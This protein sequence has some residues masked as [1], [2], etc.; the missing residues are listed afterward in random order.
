[1]NKTTLRTACAALALLT[2]GALTAQAQTQP[3]MERINA[4]MQKME[5]TINQLM[6][7]IAELEKERDAARA[8]A[9]PAA[10]AATGQ[11]GAPSAGAPAAQP[12]TCST[13]MATSRC[14][15][16][17]SRPASTSSPAST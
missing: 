13:A 8:A 7:R 12:P 10:Y 11:A 1:M 17:V 14:P 16:P 5:S 6:T 4:S 9:A 2:T 3:D 15:A